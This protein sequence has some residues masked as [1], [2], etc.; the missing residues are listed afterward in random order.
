[1]PIR[2]IRRCRRG[3][4][5]AVGGENLVAGA[6]RRLTD[7]S[8]WDGSPSWSPDGRH[9]AFVSHRDE[10]DGN[11]ELYVMGSDGSNLTRLTDHPADDWSPS[12]S[13]DGRHIAFVSERD[14]NSELYV[15][16][17]DGSNL[18]RLTDDPAGDWRPSWV[19]RWSPHR[20]CV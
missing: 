3:I 5:Q 13:P 11:F 6:L 19:S 2:P 1:M 16:G 7:H 20:L 8:G 18:T 10:D 4:G 9:I 15:M 14:G 17:S 12:F